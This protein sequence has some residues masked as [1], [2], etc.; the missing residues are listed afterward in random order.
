MN[1]KKLYGTLI[2][3]IFFAVIVI[4]ATF[5]W[6]TYSF[7]AT[8]GVY[9]TA[10]VCFDISSAEGQDINA[11]LDY[12]TNPIGGVNTSI[13]MGLQ[14]SCVISAN[15]TISINVASTTSATL[16]S[17]SEAHCENP[18]T[19]ETL[20]NYET[21]SSC[22][23]NNGTWVTTGT[24]LKYAIYDISNPTSNTTP[25]KVGYINQS[26]D[27]LLYETTLKIGATDTYYIYFWLDGELIN[28]NYMDL[29]FGGHVHAN[30]TQN[31]EYINPPEVLSGL[32]PVK[33]SASGDTVTTVATTDPEWYDYDNKKWANAVLV[34]DTGVKTRT[35]NSVVGTEIDESDI[36]A[37]YVWIPR[38]SYKV[39]QYSGASDK[40]EEREIPIKFVSTSVK[41][42]AQANGQWYTHPAFWWDNDSDGEREKDEEL[43]GIWVGKFE[44]STN[45]AVSLGNCREQSCDSS[46][47]NSLRILPNVE[48]QGISTTAGRGFF[49]SRAME[50]SDNI[51]GISYNETDS[52]MI[53][54][55]EWGAVAYLSHSRY[56]INKEVLFNNTFDYND[57]GVTRITF[58]GCGTSANDNGMSVYSSECI[59]Q[60]GT[61]SSGIYSQSTTGNITGI[62][63]MSGGA[64]EIVMGTW[65]NNNNYSNNENATGFNLTTKPL[66]DK[67]YYDNYPSSVFD[68]T[69]LDNFTKC[70]L[71][72]C[73]GHALNETK[74]WYGDGYYFV[75]SSN[76]WFIRS[77]GRYIN[78]QAPGIFATNNYNNKNSFR[79]VLIKE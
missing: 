10:T 8:N 63:D 77:S 40:G 26:G 21:S 50:N 24:A 43:T 32:I 70:T 76:L 29:S 22:E 36:L 52:H 65:D 73:G 4:G 20:Y 69:N 79:L 72:Y 23:T 55:S 38:Y 25:I 1:K 57:N 19:L 14:S 59:N 64:G 41:D 53:K 16:Y 5:A 37:Y 75:T 56:G 3:V 42:M 58:T 12:T 2:A 67:K 7:N 6:L 9:N 45:E 60:Y 48:P 30:A 17:T 28:E 18:N 15:G 51:F 35:Q 31:G 62:F 34:K 46:L 78:T 33:L 47:Y 61:V 71:E 74:R 11:T 39:W 54:N 68:G 13:A 66:P 49:V 27:N 44:T